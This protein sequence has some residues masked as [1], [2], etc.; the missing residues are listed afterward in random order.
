MPATTGLMTVDEFRQLPETGPFYYEL[1]HGELVKVTRPKKKH[2]VIQK[3]ICRILEQHA[4]E[5]FWAQEEMTFRP[6]PEHEL[7]VADIGLVTSARWDETSPDDNLPGAPGFVI[8]VLSPSNT[9]QEIFEKEQLCLENGCREFWVV[10]PK[11][12]QVKVSKPDGITR[13]YQMGHEIP[14]DLFGAGALPVAT[15]FA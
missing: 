15:I 1:R 6:L 3:R 5:K 12:R 11:L 2:A 10:D 4:G 8:E 7:R 14:L 13:T 9:V